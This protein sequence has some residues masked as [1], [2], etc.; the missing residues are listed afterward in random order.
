MFTVK[1]RIK[2]VFLKFGL[3]LFLLQL[4][5]MAYAVPLIPYK[6]GGTV[7]IDNV[8]ITQA[9]D[10]G[11]TVT[12]TKQDGTAYV[13]PAED[14]N[15]LT[16]SNWYSI[17]VPI[18]NAD[19][20]GGAA[21]G[22]TAVIHAFLNGTELT[23]N[24]PVNGQFTVGATGTTLQINIDASTPV[25]VPDPPVITNFSANPTTITTGDTSTLAWTI[26]GATSAT[27]DNGIGPVNA[28]SGNVTVN[29][30]TMTTYT[31]TATNAG[32][33]ASSKVT[34]TVQALPVPVITNF[35]ANPA[36]IQP[37]SEST[38]DWTI[39]G[40]TTAS[41]D[42]GV[43]DVDPAAGNTIVKPT[44]TTTYTLTAT[45]A[46]GSITATVTVNVQTA[47]TGVPTVTEWGMIILALGF[48]LAAFRHIR[49][50]SMS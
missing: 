38:L 11:L 46:N 39:T 6:I 33:T 18:A 20:P 17:Y 28:T 43:G 7:T 2:S 34:V 24:S 40:A 5:A 22:D 32:G 36:T 21:T 42:N 23:I 31:L 50:T 27:I 4:A 1:N 35:S 26:T 8:Q 37:G 44:V 3:A 10:D 48:G 45:N 9:T 29:P 12:V 49:K 25:P 15:G 47:T 14:T 19:Q 13:P 30:T 16:A 41:I